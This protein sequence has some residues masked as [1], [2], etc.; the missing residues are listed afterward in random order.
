MR[1]FV[2]VYLHTLDPKKRLTIPSEWRAQ[3][4]DR[5]VLYVLPDFDNQCLNVYPAEEMEHR[6]EKIRRH[7]MTD[8]KA[9]EFSATLGGSSDVV[10]WD[11]QG[12]IRIKDRLLAF[13]GILDQVVLVGALDKFQLWTPEKRP[14]AEGIDQKRLREAGRY[15]DF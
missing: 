14:E 6:I 11:A 5:K 12:R 4:G 8:S 2:G 13:A 9:M 15:V 1:V 10:L 7:S 3:A